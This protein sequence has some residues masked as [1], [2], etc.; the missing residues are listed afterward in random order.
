MS[1]GVAESRWLCTG[2]G[3]AGELLPAI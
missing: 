1:C 3:P 2:Q